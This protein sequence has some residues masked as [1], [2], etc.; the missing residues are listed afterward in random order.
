VNLMKVIFEPPQKWGGG[1]TPC[2]C[3]DMQFILS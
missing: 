3:I 1:E 2:L